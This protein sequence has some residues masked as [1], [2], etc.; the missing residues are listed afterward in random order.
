VGLGAGGELLA[1]G[2]GLQ[3]GRLG[4]EGLGAVGLG[5]EGLGA[6]GLGAV[7][8]LQL[9]TPLYTESWSSQSVMLVFLS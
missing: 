6:E 8:A 7:G 5:A 3:G 1:E 2:L 9:Y 4:A